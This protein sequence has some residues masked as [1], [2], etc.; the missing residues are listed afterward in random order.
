M[1]HVF[2]KKCSKMFTAKQSH[3]KLGY[4]IYCSIQ[5]KRN[6]QKNG[7]FVDC[8]IC[9]EKVYKPKR[10]FLRS[11]SKKYFCSKTCQ[12]IWRNKV[13]SGTNHPNWK[14]G[15]Y[16]YRTLLERNNVPAICVL[17]KVTDKRVLAVHHI[18]HDHS[19]NKLENLTY[20]CHNCH[21][22]VHHY[23]EGQGKFMVP[24]V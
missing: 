8:S 14:F 24:M 4:G 7:Y 16:V 20:L 17:C 19:N 18:D 22:L 5:C 12:A 9:K 21:H 6:A 15:K 11:K 3:L 23:N 1:P 13:F 10:I 2:C